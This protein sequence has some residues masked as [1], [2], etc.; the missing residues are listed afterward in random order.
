MFINEQNCAA[1]HVYIF[2]SLKNQ[3]F[4]IE[5]VHLENKVSLHV[6]TH[7]VSNNHRTN[8]LR[9]LNTIKFDF[10]NIWFI[11]F[12]SFL[13]PELSYKRLKV[14]IFFKKLSD[15]EKRIFVK[16]DENETPGREGKIYRPKTN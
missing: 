15:S 7:K 5:A 4:V 11:D 6:N 1:D 13:Q 14:P 8:F 12:Y 16:F 3:T 9:P 2:D 10:W